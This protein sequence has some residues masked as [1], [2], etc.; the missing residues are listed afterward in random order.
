MFMSN[1]NV[2]RGLFILCVSTLSISARMP[3]VYL[4]RFMDS[5]WRCA[6]VK[7]SDDSTKKRLLMA[8]GFL[9]FGWWNKS[10]APQEMTPELEKEVLHNI[11]TT[12]HDNID[13]LHEYAKKYPSHAPIRN[14]LMRRA[15]DVPEKG[16]ITDGQQELVIKL[17]N[18]MDSTCDPHEIIQWVVKVEQ[19]IK[20]SKVPDIVWLASPGSEEW[21]KQMVESTLNGFKSFGFRDVLKKKGI[22]KEA[23]RAAALQNKGFILDGLTREERDIIIQ[24]MELE[25]QVYLLLYNIFDE[26]NGNKLNSIIGNLAGVIYEKHSPDKIPN[27]VTPGSLF[28][29]LLKRDNEKRWLPS[30]P[31]NRF[32]VDCIVHGNIR[33]LGLFLVHCDVLFHYESHEQHAGQDFWKQGLKRY[34]TDNNFNIVVAFIKEIESREVNRNSTNPIIPW[35]VYNNLRMHK[36]VRDIAFER[37]KRLKGADLLQG[38]ADCKPLII[39]DERII[40]HIVYT[41]MLQDSVSLDKAFRQQLFTL[42]LSIVGADEECAYVIR[43]SSACVK[44]ITDFYCN[45]LPDLRDVDRIMIMRDYAEHLYPADKNRFVNAIYEYEE[46]HRGTEQAIELTKSECMF[47]ERLRRLV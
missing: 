22:L 13:K 6:L 35:K 18:H 46:K 42:V 28:S 14:A 5:V 24:S 3:G 19:E 10:E 12:P 25:D 33:H 45:N 40:D 16:Q 30:S 9:G 21:A 47:L 31:L 15:V 29:Y 37:L 43:R 32:I 8:Q 20:K 11:A 36:E 2:R 34:I 26:N 27:T 41:V 23:I 17:V 4:K 44:A 39:M 38:I 1:M 7:K